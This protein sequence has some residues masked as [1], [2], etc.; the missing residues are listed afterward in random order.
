MTR[1]TGC[2]TILTLTVMLVFVTPSRSHGCVDDTQTSIVGTG[3]GAVVGMVAT[4]ATLVVTSS[5][6]GA[7]AIATCAVSGL[8]CPLGALVGGLLAW[9]I[10][11]AIADWDCAGVITTTTDG[12]KFYASWDRDSGREAY[13]DGL[14]YCE[15][16]S[17]RPCAV[18]AEFRRCAAIAT[19]LV[20]DTWAVGRGSVGSRA[21]AR[22]LSS[23]RQSGGR[24]CRLTF[25]PV[26]NSR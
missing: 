22:A 8:L 25:G 24:R 2:A 19:S 4:G 12:E 3:A 5:A 13:L 21:K 6:V 15:E 23:C 17:G 18:L 11:S 16:Q 14:E 1:I 10:V 7:S 26:C 9:G 20:N